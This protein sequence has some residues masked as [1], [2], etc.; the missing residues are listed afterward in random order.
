MHAADKYGSM[1]HK[2]SFVCLGAATCCISP[3]GGTK[4]H[5]VQIICSHMKANYNYELT[6]LK[7]HTMLTTLSYCQFRRYTSD[8]VAKNTEDFLAS[9]TMHA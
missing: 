1:L 9:Q 4:V 2:R 6:S 7:N 8:S 3:L 5:G